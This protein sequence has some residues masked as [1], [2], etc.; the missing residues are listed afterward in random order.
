MGKTSLRPFNYDPPKDPFLDV[1]FEDPHI[2]VLNKPTGLLTVP[3]RLREH[4]DCLEARAKSVYGWAR[5]AHR[6]DRETS[7]LVV[8]GLSAEAHRGLSIG[9]ERRRVEKTYVAEVAG[10]VVG[11]AGVIDLPLAAD[12][13]NRPMQMV[14]HKRGRRAVTEWQV[15]SRGETTTKIELTPA[16]GRSHQ[17]RVHM[18]ELGHPILGDTFYAPDAV[19]EAAPRLMLHAKR[20]SFDHPMAGERLGFDV[21]L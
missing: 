10:L 2:L 13:P 3:G 16:T 20:L 14:D 12:W 6:L 7:G 9:F 17:L 8:L 18:L 21:A 4:A 11:E 15:L 5:V 19:F 1:V